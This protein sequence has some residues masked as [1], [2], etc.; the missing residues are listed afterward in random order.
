MVLFRE[1]LFN[2]N[3][4]LVPF[5]VH[6]INPPVE[7]FE[8][9]MQEGY[10]ELWRVCST[11]DESKG[12]EFST[13]AVPSIIGRIKRYLRERTNIIRIP[14][15][16]F[17]ECTDEEIKKLKPVSFN[18]S[19]ND[20]GDILEYVISDYWDF[21]ES[22]CNS[23]FIE[24]NINSV[25]SSYKGRKKDIC[26]EFYYDRLFG[27]NHNQSYYANKYRLT[28]PHVSRLLLDFK[29]DLKKK[30][31]EKYYDGRSTNHTSTT[32]K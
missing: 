17:D 19:I 31:E 11:Y 9:C 15:R 22:M 23:S 1:D 13:Y 5:C 20:N 12:F 32:R 24:N 27:E 30:M 16:M 8:D 28:Q 29:K 2:E 7:E 10:I 6:K 21:T 14:R 26:E 3:K 4:K 25:L 18:T